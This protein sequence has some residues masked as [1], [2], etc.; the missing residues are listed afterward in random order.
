MRHQGFQSYGGLQVTTP[1]EVL[2]FSDLEQGEACLAHKLLL[3]RE[4]LL[5][6]NFEISYM[7]RTSRDVGGDFLDYFYL[8]D[9]RLGIYLGDVVGKGLPAAMFA[10]LAIGTLRSIHKTGETPAAVLEAFNKRLRV[11]PDPFRYCATQYAVFDPLT[12]EL[13]VANAGIPLPLHL[14]ASGCRLLGEGGLPSGLFDLTQY[15]Q[16]T[17]QLVPGDAILFT[18]DGLPEA[19]DSDGEEFGMAQLIDVCAEVGCGRPDRLL[20]AVFTRVK[21]FASANRQDDMT[22]VVLKVFEQS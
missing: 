16:Y 8:A 11:R 9:E 17:F 13:S 7:V 15:E 19:R 4:P 1:G 18:T 2:G 12:L 14:S 20:R 22:A 3:P 5:A 10:G 6:S 21:E